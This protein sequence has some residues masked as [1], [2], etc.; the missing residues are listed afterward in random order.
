MTEEQGTYLMGRIRARCVEEGE[1]IL[2]QG[3]TNSSGNPIY[4]DGGK[5]KQLRRLVAEKVSGIKLRDGDRAFMTCRNVACLEPSHIAKG[6]GTEWSRGM[7]KS[8]AQN[9][10]ISDDRRSKSRLSMDD[11]RE[12]RASD[13]G[14]SAVGK[15]YGI[16][17]GHVMKIRNH[18]IWKDYV[19]PFAGLGARS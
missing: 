16:D 7:P 18:D 6:K 14:H 5:T 8:L 11:I 3:W 17:R 15:K 13:L 2:W 4:W 19:T 1:C 12:I 10:K 9:K